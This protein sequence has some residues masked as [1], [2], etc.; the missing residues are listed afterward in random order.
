MLGALQSPVVVNLAEYLWLSSAG[1]H[2]FSLW[3]ACEQPPEHSAALIAQLTAL[4]VRCKPHAPWFL[5][6][7]CWRQCRETQ[8]VRRGLLFCGG[9]EQLS[10]MAAGRVEEL[11]QRLVAVTTLAG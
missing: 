6:A 8:P 5:A 2:R 9:S 1:H 11:E 4:R 3:Q 7:V 10:L